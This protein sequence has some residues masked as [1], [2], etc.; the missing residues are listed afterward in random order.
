M[1]LKGKQ[2]NEHGDEND[3]KSFDD[4]NCNMVLCIPCWNNK[5]ECYER[6]VKTFK[7]ASTVRCS[8]RLKN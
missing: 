6:E 4:H 2:F 3:K 8:R 7:G 1:G 5:V